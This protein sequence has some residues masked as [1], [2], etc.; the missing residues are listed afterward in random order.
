MGLTFA[1]EVC[2]YIPLKLIQFLSIP[3]G[4][5]CFSILSFFSLSL[6]TFFLM[7]RQLL[8]WEYEGLELL[9]SNGDLIGMGDCDF[10]KSV[11]S[12]L[13]LCF[14]A[15]KI[16]VLGLVPW[17]CIIEIIPYVSYLLISKVYWEKLLMTT[18]CFFFSFFLL[19]IFLIHIFIIQHSWCI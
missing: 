18:L 2:S 16:C 13:C 17:F 9:D 1:S 12:S 5:G 19:F 4:S 14:A 8:Y 3:F 7:D 15:N 11:L 10:L 6:S